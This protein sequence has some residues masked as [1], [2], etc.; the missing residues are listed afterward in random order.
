MFDLVG[1]IAEKDKKKIVKETEFRQ[2][3]LD[4]E[5]QSVDEILSVIYD[6]SNNKK[7]KRT[8][9]VNEAQS[10]EIKF[11]DN[12]WMTKIGKEFLQANPSH[13]Y[14]KKQKKKNHQENLE[15]EEQ[16]DELFPNDNNSNSLKQVLI[17]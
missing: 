2:L 15:E 3:P 12:F 4:F 17:Y 5:N 8:N 6:K 11:Y 7:R 1:Y 14:V 13:P 16:K 10:K 9:F